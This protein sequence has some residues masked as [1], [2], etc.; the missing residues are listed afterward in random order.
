M[1]KKKRAQKMTPINRP[2]G[3]GQGDDVQS[4]LNRLTAQG[5]AKISDRTGQEV[6]VVFKSINSKHNHTLTLPKTGPLTKA[7]QKRI[8]RAAGCVV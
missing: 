2:S 3:A 6:T 5:I 8:Q 1:S 7:D 4:V